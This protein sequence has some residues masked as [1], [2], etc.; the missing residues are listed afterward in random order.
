MNSNNSINSALPTAVPLP[1][2]KKKV[3][4]PPPPRPE[5]NKKEGGAIQSMLNQVGS[6]P[7]ITTSKVPRTNSSAQPPPLHL[8][9]PPM[10]PRHNSTGN[11]NNVIYPPKPPPRVSSDQQSSNSVTPRIPPPPPRRISNLSIN[12]SPNSS[13]NPAPQA[14]SSTPAAYFRRNSNRESPP[15]LPSD[16]PTSKTPPKHT[17][18]PSFSLIKEDT[19]VQVLPINPEELRNLRLS[20]TSHNSTESLKQPGKIESKECKR[21][22]FNSKDSKTTAKQ[23]IKLCYLGTMATSTAQ[24]ILRA[25]LNNKHT[26]TTKAWALHKLIHE[27][28][29]DQNKVQLLI[30][31]KK[32]P[33]S[34]KPEFLDKV[35]AD[36]ESWE[37]PKFTFGSSELE[38]RIQEILAD[39]SFAPPLYPLPIEEGMQSNF[40]HVFPD[41]F[42][43]TFLERPE[44]ITLFLKSQPG[45]FGILHTT[46]RSNN[47]IIN[48]QDIAVR[49]Q[50]KVVIYQVKKSEEGFKPL[51]KCMMTCEGKSTT[52][53]IRSK[54]YSSFLAFLIDQQIRNSCQTNILQNVLFLKG[55]LDPL[56]NDMVK[57]AFFE[58][59]IGSFLVYKH[60][61]HFNLDFKLY[62][63]AKTDKKEP[64]VGL[65]EP[66]REF[67]FVVLEI[68][69]NKE[70]E[71]PSIEAFIKENKEMCKWALI[72]S[73][74]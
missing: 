25:H 37:I 65:L 45:S 44:F 17:R 9:L 22:E 6:S 31:E 15:K 23:A 5:E 30:L 74:H 1:I 40:T 21:Q 39:A 68:K 63:I 48:T 29:E 13:P 3:P 28:S 54:T 57:N 27:S 8:S 2:K 18:T 55:T 51:S 52:E 53:Q 69:A 14:P 43:K 16:K 36:G 60:I 49:E 73:Q 58:K 7:Q 38:A 32:E 46:V 67:E 24:D 4:P 56:S 50:D 59:R 34:V 64:N 11:I 47:A 33:S 12:S 61:N 10:H 20:L 26:T 62:V 42:S 19:R 70:G 72:E 71:Y 35:R 41:E 66:G